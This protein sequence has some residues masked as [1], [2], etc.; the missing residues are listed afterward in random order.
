[1]SDSVLTHLDDR[2]IATLTLNRPTVANAYDDQVIYSLITALD[3][4]ANNTDV[5]MLVMNATGSHFCSGADAHWIREVVSA[6]VT[7]NRNDAT[8]LARL[9]AT[10]YHFPV[11]IIAS[12]Q[13]NAYG[14]AVGIIACCDIVVATSNSQFYINDARLGL[15]PAIISP[16]LIK[17]IGEKAARFHALTTRPFTAIK[18][19][20]MGLVSQVVER[21]ELKEATQ[22]VVD[23]I[24]NLSPVAVRQ[25]KAI[26]QYSA[27]EVYDESMVDVTVEY[28]TELRASEE[29]LEGLNAFIQ[30]RNPRWQG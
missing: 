24:L 13:G 7:A 4:Y 27:N 20:K 2:G 21:E 26:I 28:L 17:A 11:P 15:A 25:T 3:D 19:M 9:M 1:M 22:L 18:A 30:K 14:G 5:R 16:Y 8:Q 10:L 12:V 23:D 29:C 6:G